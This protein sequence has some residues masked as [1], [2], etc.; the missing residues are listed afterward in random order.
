[1]LYL[2]VLY[3]YVRIAL[4]KVVHN[5]IYIYTYLVILHFKIVPN[6]IQILR[7]F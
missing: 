6:I 3:V 5:F 2:Y 7:L 4:Y 1:M